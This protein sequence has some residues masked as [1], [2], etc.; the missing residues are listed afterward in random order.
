MAIDPLREVYD[1]FDRYVR[2]GIDARLLL[3]N[4]AGKLWINFQI[5]AQAKPNFHKKVSPSRQRRREKR[6]SKQTIF[7]AA[8][9]VKNDSLPVAQSQ[10]TPIVP[11]T[12]FN[13]ED[14]TISEICFASNSNQ[15]PA[16]S[17]PR[18][19][20]HPAENAERNI[21]F[22]TSNQTKLSITPQS[23]PHMLNDLL[24][25]QMLQHGEKPHTRTV[26]QMN[27]TNK[28]PPGASAV[29]SA[30]KKCDVCQKVFET[31]DDV[32]WHRE[33]QY[34]REDCKILKSML[35]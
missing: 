33:T 17:N 15:N 30:V 32:K 5:Q 12:K 3:E 6:Q 7:A 34:G 14:V 20:H 26:M 4:H 8:N 25:A 1:Q 18:S 35:P 13:T 19:F 21:D 16:V 2:A 24:P 9:A 31:Q 22:S 29:V 11:D 23:L 27:S 28:S 10:V